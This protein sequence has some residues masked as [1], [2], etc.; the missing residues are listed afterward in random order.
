MTNLLTHESRAA[1]I[2]VDTETWTRYGTPISLDT[3]G[4]V[5]IVNTLSAP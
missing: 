3:G 4:T 1:V 5:L 2:T